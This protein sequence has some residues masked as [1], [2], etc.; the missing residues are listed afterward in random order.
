MS[1]QPGL[2]QS[3]TVFTHYQVVMSAPC[4]L[5]TL[6]RTL[7]S[8]CPS[9]G[10]LHR[11]LSVRSMSSKRQRDHLQRTAAQP[12]HTH[13]NIGFAQALYPA[14]VCGISQESESV[15]RLRLTVH[16]DFSF[17]AGQWV[18]LFIP[19]LATVGGF[20]MCSSPG[21]LQREGVIELAVKY[22]DHPPAHWLHTKCSLGSRVKVRAGGEF[23]FDPGP[24]DVALDLLL[25][26]GGVGINPLYSILLHTAELLRLKQ[27]SVRSVHLSFS[28]KSPQELLFKSSISETCALFP[29]VLSC[30]FHVTQGSTELE[31][32]MSRGRISID[33]LRAHVRPPS[34]LCYLC[35]PPTMIESLSVSLQELGLPPER[36]RFEKWW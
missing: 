23:F 10:A 14:Q 30:D 24:C 25:V 9:L 3:D 35:G 34:S 31:P 2:T 18:D 36:V 19:G 33:D 32:P 27:D 22:T 20:S 8:Y 15:K 13:A 16:P 29:S 1:L 5:L 21:L 11:G 7:P 26:A 17:K 12:R 4:A 6:S 28:A